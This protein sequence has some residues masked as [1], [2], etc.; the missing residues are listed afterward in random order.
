MATASSSAPAGKGA[1][2]HCIIS[3]GSA[4]IEDYE[5][6]FPKVL[7]FEKISNARLRPYREFGAV[8]KAQE[9]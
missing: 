4:K 5:M 2:L 9:N 8:K 6:I 7:L 3:I 1:W